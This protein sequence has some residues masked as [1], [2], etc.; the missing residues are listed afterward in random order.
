[1]FLSVM[2]RASGEFVSEKE[3]Q[4][5][6]RAQDTILGSVNEF[7]TIIDDRYV[8]RGYGFL[9]ELQGSPGLSSSHLSSCS[10]LI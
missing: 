10:F 7:T 6:I 5:A 1:M 8:P 9:V 3:L 2:M 4:D